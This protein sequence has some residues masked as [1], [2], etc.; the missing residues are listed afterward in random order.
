MLTDRIRRIWLEA[1]HSGSALP[2]EPTLARQLQASRPA[3][4]EA[5]ARLE[6]EGLIHRRQGA[7]TAVNRAA[8]GI[9]ARLDQQVDNEEII[10]AMGHKA[11]VDVL[12]AGV[13][14]L[15]QH[16]STAL[17]VA[18]GSPALRVAKRWSADGVPVVLAINLVPLLDGTRPPELDESQSLF[19]LVERLGH[20]AV[21]W[22]LAWPSAT[23]LEPPISDWLEQPPGQAAL[24]LETVGVSRAGHRA[25]HASEYHVPDAVRYGLI[26]SVR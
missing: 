5:L 14:P 24:T 3:V 22:E 21:E 18:V 16:D 20:Q 1:V 23:N 6:A 7:E 13:V 4:R 9:A 11:S 15:D 17:E 2:G 10:R 8:M 25:Y 26:R 19:R 12:E